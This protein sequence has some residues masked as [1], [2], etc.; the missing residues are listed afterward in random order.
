M[1]FCERQLDPSYCQYPRASKQYINTLTIQLSVA[2][3]YKFFNWG[4][5]KVFSL[6][7]KQPLGCEDKQ[8]N[9]K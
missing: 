1:E 5:F 3:N 2:S 9:N 6:K 7:D 4:L 8:K